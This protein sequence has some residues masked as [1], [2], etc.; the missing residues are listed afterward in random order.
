MRQSS[1]TFSTTVASLIPWLLPLDI[2][3]AL[4]VTSGAA[5]ATTSASAPTA[6]S[7]P[8]RTLIPY[9]LK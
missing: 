5:P 2:S 8:E 1:P 3:M 6:P 7:G 4:R 9:S